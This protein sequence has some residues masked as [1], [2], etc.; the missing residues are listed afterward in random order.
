VASIVFAGCLSAPAGTQNEP[1]DRPSNG[2]STTGD[3]DIQRVDTPP[4]EI[5]KPECDPPDDKRDPLWLCGNMKAEPTLQFDQVETSGSVLQNEGFQSDTDDHTNS[6]FYTTLLTTGDDLDRI[7]KGRDSPAV[8]LI[9]ETEFDSQAVLIVQTGWGSGF[10]TPHLKRIE[11]TE[12]GVHAYGCY[13]RP[14]VWTD[15]YTTRTVVAQ[16]ERPDSLDTGI[17][18]LTVD[19][20]TRVNF[21]TNEGVVTVGTV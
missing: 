17:V 10:I 18:S 7:D 19:A 2:N 6:Q 15:D 8:E 13:R 9:E 4:Y 3:T 21:Q 20:E 16:F 1:T 14:C 5:T 12:D 11:D